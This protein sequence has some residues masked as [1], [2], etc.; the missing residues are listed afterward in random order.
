MMGEIRRVNEKERTERLVQLFSLVD[1]N[2]A[3]SE[4]LTALG[5]NSFMNEARTLHGEI[6]RLTK[7]RVKETSARGR[8][9]TLAVKSEI[10]EAVT[11]FFQ[12]IELASIENPDVDY[13]LLISELNEWSI[14]YQSLI[15]GRDTRSEN[16]M[17]N[18]MKITKKTAALSPTTSAT[19]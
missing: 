4:A 7:E 14:P 2:T 17:E 12:R 16:Q 15:K 5:F 6:D 1:S 13:T 3:L 19:A 9:E 8:I 18:V 11:N 10:S